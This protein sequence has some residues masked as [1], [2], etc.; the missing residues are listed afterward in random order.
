MSEKQNICVCVFT[1]SCV[2]I[3]NMVIEKCRAWH[4]NT[5][6]MMKITFGGTHHRKLVDYPN[7]E[8]FSPKK[9]IGVKDPLFLESDPLNIF[10]L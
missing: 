6:P 8:S 1:G 5:W 3:Q 2:L 10:A 7:R 4:K 9:G